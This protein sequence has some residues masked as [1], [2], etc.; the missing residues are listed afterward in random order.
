MMRTSPAGQ[1]KGEVFIMQENNINYTNDELE[2]LA[3]SRFGNQINIIRHA[4]VDIAGELVAGALLGQILYWFEPNK[5][6]K[7]KLRVIKDN[8]YWLVKE[9]SD[10]Y[11]EIRISAKQYDRAAKVLDSKGLIVRKKYKFNG[12]PMIHIR[13]NFEK[14]NSEIRKWLDETKEIIKQSKDGGKQRGKRELPKGENP[15]VS[16]DVEPERKGDVPNLLGIDQRGKPELTKG[17][18]RNS[19]KRKTGIDQR[20]ISLTEITTETTTETTHIDHH[21]HLNS[22]PEEIKQPEPTKTKYDDDGYKQLRNIFV[23][24]KASDI[25][26]HDKHYPKYQDAVKAIGFDKLIEASKKYANQEKEYSQIVWFLAGGYNNYLKDK[27]KQQTK[28][29]PGA[30]VPECILKAQKETAVT[31]EDTRPNEAD[32]EASKKHIEDKLKQMQESLSSGMSPEQF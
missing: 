8:Y 20:G 27:S 30:V 21:Q 5:D 16:S 2:V 23:D 12:N 13:P 32:L 24:A 3:Q 28:I 31:Q 14:I 15:E 11:N 1:I 6:G 19:P 29:N 9:R 7:T 18:N 17:E 22:Q 10:W 4:Y 26:A 25:K